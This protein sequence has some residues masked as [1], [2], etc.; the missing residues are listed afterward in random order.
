[1]DS[2][3]NIV[4]TTDGH[5]RTIDRF[6]FSLLENSEADKYCDTV[7]SLDLKGDAWVLATIVSENKKYGLSEFIPVDFSDLLLKLDDRSI[8]KF[9]RE[10]DSQELVRSL[11][12]VTVEVQNRIFNNMSKKAAIM[13]KEDMEYMGPVRLIDV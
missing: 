2:N 11:K 3:I 13:L 1:M 12:N 10:I 9:M 7:N 5:N 6:S 8:Q 4:V